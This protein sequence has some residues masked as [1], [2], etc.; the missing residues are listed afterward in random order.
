[1]YSSSLVPPGVWVHSRG[2]VPAGRQELLDLLGEHGEDRIAQLG[3]DEA[4]QA[5]GDLAQRLRPLVAQQVEGHE[6]L[7]ARD[8]GN[9]GL[10][11]EDARDSGCRDARLIGDVGQGDALV[12][13][14]LLG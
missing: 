13:V 2:G 12:H 11:V 6:H 14:V 1:M 4:D 5:L 9:I 7:P 10:A 3:D 8:L